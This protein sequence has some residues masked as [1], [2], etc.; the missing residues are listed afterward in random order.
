M[1]SCH[2]SSLFAKVTGTSLVDRWRTTEFP[3]PSAVA[4]QQLRLAKQSREESD[5]LICQD[6]GVATLRRIMHRLLVAEPAQ[7]AQPAPSS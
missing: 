1:P 5:V 6:S 3:L 7:S 2:P 4:L